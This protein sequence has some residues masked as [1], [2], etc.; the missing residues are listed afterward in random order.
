MSDME[1][2]NNKVIVLVIG[3][4]CVDQLNA[5]HYKTIL[6][7]NRVFEPVEPNMHTIY[8]DKYNRLVLNLDE[9]EGL[10]GKWKNPDAQILSWEFGPLLLATKQ[11]KSEYKAV[12][13]SIKLKIAI[14][15]FTG[16]PVYAIVDKKI[17]RSSFEEVYSRAKKMNLITVTAVELIDSPCYGPHKLEF[18]DDLPVIKVEKNPKI[19]FT[20]A[21]RE[22]LNRKRTKYLKEHCQEEIEAYK[23]R[24]QL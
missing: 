13:D 7:D 3:A 23:R 5:L 9:V 18:I 11:G 16:I 6:L 4:N 15:R 2:V 19:K 17:V 21:E 14:K 12:K 24:K 22:V 8:D 20:R 1:I 10:W